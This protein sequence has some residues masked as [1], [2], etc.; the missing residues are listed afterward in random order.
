MFRYIRSLFHSYD[1]GHEY[2]VRLGDIQITPQFQA[3][4]IGSLKYKRKWQFYRRNGYC[5]SKIILDKSFVLLDGYSS[6]KILKTAEGLD[7]KVPVYFV[8]VY[9]SEKD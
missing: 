1:V 8:E 4:R 7:T 3:T 5:E 6:Y 9:V 2:W